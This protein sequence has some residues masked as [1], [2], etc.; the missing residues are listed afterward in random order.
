MLIRMAHTTVLVLGFVLV[1]LALFACGKE[2]Q[3]A[4]IST[5]ETR[6]V[7]KATVKASPQA[8]PTPTPALK[9]IATPTPT[10]SE[11]LYSEDFEDGPAQNWSLEPGWQVSK[12]NGNTVLLG[13][14]HYWANLTRGADWTDYVLKFRL[15]VRS[16]AVHLNYRMGA[17][18]FSRYFLSFSKEGLTL[19]KQVGD[20]FTE[21]MDNRNSYHLNT[22]HTVEIKGFAGHLQVLV[23][24]VLELDLT[25]EEPLLQGTIAF[26]SLP[27]S[28]VLI[29]D[30]EIWRHTEPLTAP[31]PRPTGLWPW[32]W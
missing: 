25:D 1:P 23:D 6:V 3:I 7:S 18:P 10:P 9:L 29:D 21:M 12:E 15:K 8:A 14:G 24:G 20:D 32:R 16:A 19:T 11:P 22:W 30:I 31:Q 26:E 17:N 2:S 28:E 13:R 27:G 5:P 4:D